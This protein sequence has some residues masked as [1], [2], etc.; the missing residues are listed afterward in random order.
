MVSATITG[1]DRGNILSDQNY[2]R[3]TDIVATKSNPHPTVE[4]AETP[5]YNLIIDHPE[6][7]LL[8]DT[9]SHPDAGEGYWP[10][11]LYDAFE[12][13]DAADHALDDEL[14]QAGYRISDIDYVIQTHLHMDHAGGLY[15]FE[16]TDTPIIVHEDELKFAYYSSVTKQGSA[17]YVKQDF[18]RD[19]NWHVIHQDRTRLFEDI[20]FIRLKGH[21]PGTLAML[22]HL[23]RDESVLFTSDLIEVRENYE[24]HRPPGP[25]I[26]WDRENWFSSLHTLHELEREHD[27]EVIYGHEQSQ[28]SRI[29]DGWP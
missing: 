4:R 14:S 28:L 16:D 21:S 1:L 24:Q 17:G 9:G 27:A 22:I 20:E 12:H 15:L 19:L 10:G 6:G 23:D 25:G 5:V 29:L 13:Y 8:W 26:L 2:H 7:T 18:D 11:W 3:E